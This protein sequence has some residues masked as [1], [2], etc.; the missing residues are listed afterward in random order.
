MRVH[1]KEGDLVKLECKPAL[2]LGIVIEQSPPADVCADDPQY[3]PI[4]KVRW[5]HRG[6]GWYSDDELEVVSESR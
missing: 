3:N 1:M 5:P 4:F 6:R 2:G